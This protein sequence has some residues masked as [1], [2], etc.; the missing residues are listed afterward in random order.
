M[1][2]T[3]GSFDY[4]DYWGLQKS[5]FSLAPCPQNLYLSRQHAECLLRLKY[6]VMAEK[7]GALLI[8][9]SAGDG[10]TTILRRLCNDLRDELK[11]KIRIA[12]VDHPTLTPLQMLQEISRQVGIA[13]PFRSKVRALAV[14]REHLTQLREQGEK[15]LVIVDE[16]QM[17]EHH[18]ELL[19]E[20][21]I[22][23]NLYQRDEFLL[24]FILSGQLPLEGII[25]AMPEFWQRLPVR[26]FLGN[27]DLGDTRKLIQ[28]RLRCA[29]LAE[30]REVFTPGASER[31]FTFSQGCPR[32][33][34]SIADLALV[35]GRS[36][37][38][39][40]V[41]APQVAQAYADMEKRSSD[42]YHYYHFVKSALDPKAA[43]RTL[44]P[45]PRPDEAALRVVPVKSQVLP[46]AAAPRVPAQ[47]P[48][49]ARRHS[50]FRNLFS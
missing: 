41:D 50:W 36:D 17:L 39:R 43:K 31:V 46:A 1:P 28:H 10:K 47:R 29:G 9:D 32:V 12:F 15:C 35:V 44:R 25:R 26:F 48:R 37:G 38:V 8:S 34:C 7:G 14:L 18:P 22:L 4:L 45:R 13:N 16:G 42:G 3:T 20:L 40:K 6:A 2:E 11:G 21:R 24:S 33:I 5:P 23:L 27:L 49:P 30:G 19:Q